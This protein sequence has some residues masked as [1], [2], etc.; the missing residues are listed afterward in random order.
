[1]QGLMRSGVFAWLANGRFIIGVEDRR[2]GAHGFYDVA[3]PRPSPS[4]HAV[5][6]YLAV[7][8]RLG[9]PVHNHFEWL[10]E[11]PEIAG[12]IQARWH[13][14]SATWLALLPG[15]RWPNKRWPAEYFAELVKRFSQIDPALRFAILGGAEDSEAATH[16]AEAN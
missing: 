6:W 8:A 1:L 4:T 10:P 3:V 12:S 9:V 14:D 15:A 5:D 16:I 13:A 7:L 2:E 11:R